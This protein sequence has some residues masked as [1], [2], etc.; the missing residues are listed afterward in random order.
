MHVSFACISSDKLR[1]K[2][3]NLD[4]SDDTEIREIHYK[5]ILSV[6]YSSR[7]S[8]VKSIY[9]TAKFLGWAICKVMHSIHP[10]S[11]VNN[12]LRRSLWKSHLLSSESGRRT[13]TGQYKFNLSQIH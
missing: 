13:Q 9:Y 2:Q 8:N 4:N 12:I 11:L 7:N 5:T 1:V 3:E 10:K 6:V